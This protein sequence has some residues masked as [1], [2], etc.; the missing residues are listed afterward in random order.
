MA[1]RSVDK[2]Y[3]VLASAELHRKKLAQKAL[4]V[5]DLAGRGLT[6]QLESHRDPNKN[7]QVET[8]HKPTY[9]YIKL[10]RQ[11]PKNP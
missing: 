1:K 4:L 2:L 7:E 11:N 10:N 5:H 3:S 8:P 6:V 9:L